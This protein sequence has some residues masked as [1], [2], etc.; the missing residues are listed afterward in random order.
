M[1]FTVEPKP[2]I[3]IDENNVKFISKWNVV[4]EKGNLKYDITCKSDTYLD[5]QNHP[6]LFYNAKKLDMEIPNEYYEYTVENNTEF[7]TI[8][9]K[10]IDVLKLAIYKIFKPCINDKRLTI[11]RQ[12]NINIRPKKIVIDDDENTSVFPLWDEDGNGDY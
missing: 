3:D 10:N 11:K 5:L 4:L 8:S 1:S 7:I 12:W 9:S 6:S 2:I